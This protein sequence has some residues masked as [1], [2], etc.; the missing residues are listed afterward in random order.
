MSRGQTFS[1]ARVIN[2]RELLLQR[3]CTLP[4]RTLYLPERSQV[5]LGVC[6]TCSSLQ[7]AV[8]SLNSGRVHS[9][10]GSSASFPPLVSQ[11][12]TEPWEPCTCSDSNAS[13]TV[14]VRAKSSQQATGEVCPSLLKLE[15]RLKDIDGSAVR[16]FC[17]SDC[18]E[19]RHGN[20][21]GFSPET[22][23]HD[24]WQ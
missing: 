4:R 18:S 15:R 1:N 13:N 3:C 5:W 10:A 23:R 19:M 20:R 6:T 12:R 14:E 24:A 11:Y 16:Y 9:G 2:E 7:F 17:R 21:M 22:G 8:T